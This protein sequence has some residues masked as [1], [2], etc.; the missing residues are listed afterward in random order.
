MAGEQDRDLLSRT[1]PD[2][3]KFLLERGRTSS[4]EMLESNRPEEVT[5]GA[6][7]ELASMEKE[8]IFDEQS[9]NSYGIQ[10]T[11]R[12]MRAKA[13]VL[14]FVMP[15][16]MREFTEDQV[17]DGLQNRETRE[18]LVATIRDSASEIMARKTVVEKLDEQLAFADD[19]D[20]YCVTAFTRAGKKRVNARQYGEILR[21]RETAGEFEPFGSKVAKAIE[22]FK[23]VAEGKAEVR[24]TKED[25]ERY[26]FEIEADEIQGTLPNIFALP[27]NFGLLELSMEKYVATRIGYKIPETDE[28]KR[29]LEIKDNLDAA[30]T[31]Y[32][33]FRHWDY[34]LVYALGTKGIGKALDPS[35]ITEK[36]M[37]LVNLDIGRQGT[38]ASKL[39]IEMRRMMESSG[40]QEPYSKDETREHPRAAGAL[41][42][43]GCYPTLTAAF[44]QLTMIEGV[45]ITRQ[46]PDG[47]QV[48]KR[49]KM[50]IDMLCFGDG[51]VQVLERVDENGNS[52]AEP[53]LVGYDYEKI[54]LT[55]I[56]WDKI[57]SIGY[58]EESAR[59]ARG[60]PI[61]KIALTEEGKRALAV[62][63]GVNADAFEVP[64]K[65]EQYYAALWMFTNFMRT[66]FVNLYTEALGGGRT[67]D[68][69]V[70]MNKAIDVALSIMGEAYGLDEEL[71]KKLN[72]YVRVVFL[73]S[74]GSAITVM[75]KDMATTGP[76]RKRPQVSELS[77]KETIEVNLIRAAIVTGFL[78]TELTQEGMSVVK[79]QEDLLKQIINRKIAPTPN[80]LPTWFTRAELI[81]LAPLYPLIPFPR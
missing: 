27:L 60:R 35:D 17:K 79:E 32:I 53:R 21:T 9:P 73:G 28:A 68:L 67:P 23:E 59:D 19:V 2:A 42:S 31:G 76:R 15:L 12:A 46:K 13:D 8:A 18:K 3:F 4:L 72:N 57:V 51:K 50:T 55:K 65:L 81:R 52:L 75:P 20:A 77:R 78:T 10:M 43:L 80:K 70:K 37:S 71:T 22:A 74:I 6:R 64:Y 49:I 33:L 5:L 14:E 36:D 61:T 41:A 25:A 16:G 69:L 7:I 30:M 11:V 66:D 54:P 56:P 45:E 44:P 26:G 48:K 63:L 29:A 38:D 40:G 58:I 24:L 62:S 1:T 39:I 47:E 34:P